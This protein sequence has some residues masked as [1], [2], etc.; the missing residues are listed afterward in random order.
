VIQQKKY[1]YQIKEILKY[2][3]IIIECSF[4]LDEDLPHAK[5][6]KHMAWSN[7]KPLVQS[8]SQIQWILTHFSQKYKK[9][10]VEN[11]FKMKI[12]LI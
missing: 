7:L 3:N 8:N 2:P 9:E 5:E 10:L 4:I 6:K 12:C 11:F 1:F